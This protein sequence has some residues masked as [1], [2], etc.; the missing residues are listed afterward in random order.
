MG[1][2]PRRAAHARRARRRVA[3]DR[4]Y[5]TPPF[6]ASAYVKSGW[7]GG[8]DWPPAQRAFRPAQD[9]DPAVLHPPREERATRRLGDIEMHV[10]RA[11]A[12]L[13]ELD[14]GLRLIVGM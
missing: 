9:V 14:V 11:P 3:A 7:V 5:V 8:G 10:A 2:T 4:R 1:R 12:P 6:G 13:G